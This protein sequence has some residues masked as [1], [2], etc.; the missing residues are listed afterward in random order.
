MR[1]WIAS[2]K[3]GERPSLPRLSVVVQKGNVQVER[4][5]ANGR[6]TGDGCLADSTSS[7]SADV[8]LVSGSLKLDRD[9]QS[10]ACSCSSLGHGFDRPDYQLCIVKT[11]SLTEHITHDDAVPGGMNF[12]I[13]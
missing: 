13:H 1:E 5:N 9:V 7:E 11:I 3:I 4:G 8:L 2:Q 12:L 6:Q 10:L